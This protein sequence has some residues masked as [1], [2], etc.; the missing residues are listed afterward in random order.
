MPGRPTE[1]D[2]RRPLVLVGASCG[3]LDIFLSFYHFSCLSTSHQEIA[4]YR[5]KYCLKWPMNTKQ[6][7]DQLFFLFSVWPMLGESRVFD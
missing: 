5:L 3:C 4:Q 6:P 1:F 2:N 7:T